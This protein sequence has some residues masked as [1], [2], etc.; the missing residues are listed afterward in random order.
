MSVGVH[1]VEVELNHR[2]QFSGGPG[3]GGTLTQYRGFL[4][5]CG[6]EYTN[7]TGFTLEEKSES[8]YALPAAANIVFG[9]VGCGFTTLIE[10]GI[11][12]LK[13]FGGASAEKTVGLEPAANANVASSLE[14]KPIILWA[15]E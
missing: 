4:R 6:H 12:K 10:P 9:V 8:R 13:L 14:N 5:S 3:G 1:A 2:I 15:V 11:G 7:G